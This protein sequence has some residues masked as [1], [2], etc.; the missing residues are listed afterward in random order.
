MLVPEIWQ[1]LARSTGIE[2]LN[3]TTRDVPIYEEL[4]QLRLDTLEHHDVAMSEIVEVIESLEPLSGAIDFMKWARQRFQVVI[5][6]DTFY[7]FAMPL[8]S[9]LGYPLLLSHHLVIRDDR[10]VDYRLRLDDPKRAAVQAFKSLNFKV[11]A[12][13]DS[14]NDVGMLEAADR[15]YFFDAP[16]RVSLDYPKIPTIFGYQNLIRVLDEQ[17]AE[18]L[19]QE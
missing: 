5:L 12:A 10:I 8:I 11:F 1:A 18:A 2:K 15:G 4:M 3:A 16:E 17:I 6:S 7:E 9:K 13:G 19:V 14:Y